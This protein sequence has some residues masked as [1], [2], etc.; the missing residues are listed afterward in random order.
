VQL[1]ANVAEPADERLLDV[2]MN[3]FQ[4]DGILERA[5]FD[6]A[7]DVVQGGDDHLR[8]VRAQQ[9]DVSEHAGVRLAGLNIF[10]IKALI[11]ADRFG[12]LLDA[13]IGAAAESAAPG[14]L[15]GHDIPLIRPASIRRLRLSMSSSHAK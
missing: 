5:A 10:A 14:F 4:L 9:A 12:E 11:E 2:R 13:I 3:V 6:F 1:A 15:V 8:F 7:A